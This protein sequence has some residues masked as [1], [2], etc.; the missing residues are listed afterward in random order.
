MGRDR[1]ERGEER[2]ARGGEKNRQVAVR[3][4]VR[5]NEN[6]HATAKRTEREIK[7]QEKR[8]ICRY[9]RYAG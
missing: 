7:Y 9:P 6:V 3:R 4:E 5:Q 8:E 1:S 2:E